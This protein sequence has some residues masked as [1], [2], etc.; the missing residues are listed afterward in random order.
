MLLPCRRK[1]GR[2]S[3]PR[4]FA[5]LLSLALGLP[6]SEALFGVGDVV[7][8]P[9]NFVQNTETAIQA[10][11]M[12]AKAVEQIQ[13][14]VTMITHQVAQIQH[15][16]TNLERLDPSVLD[17][18]NGQIDHF[19]AVIKSAHGL[20]YQ[21]GQIAEQFNG[22][23][24]EFGLPPVDGQTYREEQAAWNQQ[25]PLALE[26]AVQAQSIVEHIATDQ[27]NL[28]ATVAW[29][30]AAVGNLQVLQAGN[31]IQGLMATQLMRLQQIMVASQRAQAAELARQA[32]ENDQAQGNARRLME[33]YG[34]MG[35]TH[36]RSSLP[37]L[38]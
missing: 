15:Q 28:S 7:F 38:Q 10:A 32:S 31:Q 24:P 29:S 17:S 3:R 1:P 18:M 26:Q 34:E 16:L 14:Q 13:N 25:T 23:Y 27:A 30:Q 11:A 35:P 21:V 37:P 36:P 8:D 5:L 9:T 12:V 33:G 6:A 22:L 19:M 4:L 20:G 2:Q